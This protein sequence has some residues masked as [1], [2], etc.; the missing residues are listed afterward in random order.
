MTSCRGDWPMR[1]LLKRMSLQ[2][3]Y[4]YA[5]YALLVWFASWCFL[6]DQCLPILFRTSSNGWDLRKER[7]AWRNYCF[8]IIFHHVPTLVYF[9]HIE[10]YSTLQYT[11]SVQMWQWA[12]AMLLPWRYA[13]MTHEIRSTYEFVAPRSGRAAK[14]GEPCREKITPEAFK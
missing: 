5:C 1:G 6:L 4:R 9:N 14:A 2:T 7:D 10:L 12:F 3:S 13:P 11:K 8:I